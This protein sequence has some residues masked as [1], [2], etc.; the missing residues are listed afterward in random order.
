[1]Q[2]NAQFGGGFGGGIAS[3]GHGSYGAPTNFGTNRYYGAVIYGG[4]HGGNKLQLKKKFKIMFFKQLFCRRWLR[5]QINFTAGSSKSYIILL[6]IILKFVTMIL[7]F[8]KN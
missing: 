2:A 1:L 3:G 5:A 7:S 6:P 8:E 4:G